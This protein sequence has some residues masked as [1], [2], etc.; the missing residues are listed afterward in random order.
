MSFLCDFNCS[1]D[2]H[3]LLWLMLIVIANVVYQFDRIYNQLGNKPL[4]HAQEALSK[5]G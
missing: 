3:N 5:L 4:G 2:Q 1:Y